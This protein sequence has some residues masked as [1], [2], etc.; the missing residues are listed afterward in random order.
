MAEASS[1]VREIHLEFLNDRLAQ[2]KLIQ[3]FEFLCPD[4]KRVVGS[5]KTPWPSLKEEDS[6]EN[7]SNLRQSIL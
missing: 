2:A 3:A 5:A 4:T 6:D 1:R 7:R